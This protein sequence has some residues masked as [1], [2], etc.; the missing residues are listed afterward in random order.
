[1][2][3]NSFSFS[4]E[5]GLTLIEVVASLAL[6]STLLVGVLVAFNQHSRQIRAGNRKLDVLHRVDALL[7][8]WAES[9]STIPRAGS[10][11]I[12][13]DDDLIWKTR[14]VDT[15]YRRNLGVDVVRIEVFAKREAL[16]ER[17]IVSLDLAVSSEKWPLEG[18]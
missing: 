10:G 8:R 7:Y 4:A 1:M 6:L 2:S 15:R 16:L 9:G 12:L 13:G 17:P 5:A 11:E 3:K 14:V 18:E